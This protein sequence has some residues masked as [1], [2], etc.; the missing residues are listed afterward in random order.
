MMIE[1]ERSDYNVINEL[2]VEIENL[3]IIIVFEYL[4]LFNYNI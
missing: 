4:V 1:I 3:M 2:F